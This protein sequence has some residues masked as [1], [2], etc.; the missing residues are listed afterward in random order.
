MGPFTERYARKHLR[1]HGLPPKQGRKPRLAGLST[2]SGRHGRGDGRPFPPARSTGAISASAMQ[3]TGRERTAVPGREV[4]REQP[5]RG[6]LRNREPERSQ[7]YEEIERYV[8]LLGEFDLDLETVTRS[9]PRREDALV[10][11]RVIA[12][13]VASDP[14]LYGQLRER[15]R[16]PPEAVDACMPLGRNIVKRHGT[17]IVA[18]ALVTRDEFPRLHD[19]LW[20]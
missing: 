18:L 2:G 6:G 1:W 4:A 14:A 12:S 10:T 7:R 3:R 17:Y 15:R 5:R 19:Y 8:H 9:A 13:E 11:A 20:S 16:L